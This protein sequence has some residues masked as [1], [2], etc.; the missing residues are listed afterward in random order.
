MAKFNPAKIGNSKFSQGTFTLT[1]PQKYIGSTSPIYRSSWER[2]YM[3]TCDLNPAIIQ[4]GA[5]PFSI[6]YI[7]PLTGAVKNYWPD[8]IVCYMNRSGTIQRELVEIKPQKESLIEVAK[9]KRDKL[10]LLVNQ[11]KWAAAMKFCNAN[12]LT[13][14]VLTEQ[15]LYKKN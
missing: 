1:N 15:Q 10:N 2:D 11:A 9:S 3:Y 5:E 13:F 14:R 6:P 4:W 8:F 7:D 12:N